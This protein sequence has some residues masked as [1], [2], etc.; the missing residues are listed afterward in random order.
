M[1]KIVLIPDSFKLTMSSR[2][3]L[4]IMTEAVRRHFPSCNIVAIEACD[5]GE[6]TVDAFLSSCGG[7]KISCTVSGPWGESVDSS[8]A[9][10]DNG[11][12]LVESASACGLAL[13]KGRLDP[14]RTTSRGLGQ[15][16]VMSAS[17][18]AGRILIGLGGSATNDAGCGALCECGIR[19]LDSKGQPFVPTGATLEEVEDID[20]SECKSVLS[21]VE[22]VCLSDVEN[23]FY[24]PDGASCVFAP[25]KGADSA[26][27]ALLDRNME[28]FASVVERATGIDL[29]SMPGSGAAGGLGGSLASLLGARLQSG[30][31]TLLDEVDFDRIA[32]DAD[33][34]VTGEGRLDGQS[35]DGK[36]VGSLARRCRKLGVPLVAIA[37]EL[38]EGYEKL[39]MQGLSSCWKT[40]TLSLPFEEA[41]KRC[42]EDLAC[43]MDRML[44]SL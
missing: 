39:K 5:G 28:H 14:S 11:S 20:A 12:A 33:L 10:L 36:L 26:M 37:G 13:A 34:V 6:G 43:T 40:N 17:T 21:D 44:S 22:L 35:A 23:I 38:G 41:R 2:T 30:A 8:F 24:G 16:I 1:R 29:Q 4:D 3:V 19:F 32:R 15:L 42:R 25:Q 7:K 27:V 18:G 9:I 31:E